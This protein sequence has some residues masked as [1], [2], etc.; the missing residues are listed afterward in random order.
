MQCVLLALPGKE[1]SGPVQH[2]LTSTTP[3]G[4]FLMPCLFLA[5]PGKEHLTCVTHSCKPS[6]MF[7]MACVYSLHCLLK[8]Q[9][10]RA[11]HF[12][13]TLWRVFTLMPCMFLALPGKEAADLC[14]TFLQHPLVCFCCRVCV[15][16][17]AW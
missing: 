4:V 12:Y 6:G 7:L 11:T 14:N 2:I 16:C 1:N 10:T 5:L 9:Q 3:S 17:T 15:P 8:K 13:N